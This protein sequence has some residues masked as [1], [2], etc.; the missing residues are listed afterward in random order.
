MAGW[1]KRA[2]LGQSEGVTQKQEKGGRR[3]EMEEEA[4]GRTEG[5]NREN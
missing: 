2:G 1:A 5:G 3:G 4:T